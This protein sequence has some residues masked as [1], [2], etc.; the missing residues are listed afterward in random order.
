PTGTSEPAMNTPQVAMAEGSAQLGEEP[1]PTQLHLG[2]DVI[3]RS[4]SREPDNLGRGAAVPK[5]ADASLTQFRQLL[6]ELEQ[7]Y[8]QDMKR[9]TRESG[10]LRT[11]MSDLT[12]LS[13]QKVE[14]LLREDSGFFR[15]PPHLVSRP[16]LRTSGSE[17]TWQS[18][19]DMG[20]SF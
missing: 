1:R 3:G 18:S 2:E 5:L 10:L 9:W 12:G 20:P 4:T 17:H 13:T 6:F 7:Q 8:V 19:R 11:E 15:F 16:S 14:D